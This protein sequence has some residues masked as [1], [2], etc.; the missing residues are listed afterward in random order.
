MGSEMCIRDSY[1]LALTLYHQVPQ[2]DDVR[3]S[4]LA[5]IKAMPFKNESEE[6]KAAKPV[7]ISDLWEVFTMNILMHT[8]HRLRSYCNRLKIKRGQNNVCIFFKDRDRLKWLVHVHNA[9][10]LLQEQG[11]EKRECPETEMVDL[12]YSRKVE[13]EVVP[14]PWLRPSLRP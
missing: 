1:T 5:Q 2:T 11:I 9:A 3:A 4:V 14:P 7:Y 10:V 12:F 13:L 8:D 6:Q